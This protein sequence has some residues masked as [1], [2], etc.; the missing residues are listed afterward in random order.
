M[1]QPAIISSGLRVVPLAILEE[2]AGTTRRKAPSHN[3]FAK[4]RLKCVRTA[5]EGE[6]CKKAAEF[7]G[8]EDV[9]FLT[10]HQC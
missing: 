5:S 4:A 7:Q 2:E 1:I 9:S 8:P 6:V 10:S 3:N